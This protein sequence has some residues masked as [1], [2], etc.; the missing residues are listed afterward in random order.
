MSASTNNDHESGSG[1]LP[2]PVPLEFFDRPQSDAGVRRFRERLRGKTANSLMS[3][4]RFGDYQLEELIGSGAMGKVYKARHIE[5]GRI[6]AVKVMASEFLQNSEAVQRFHKEARL[7]SDV[8]SQHITRMYDVSSHEDAI[9]IV[10]EFVNGITVADLLSREVRLS[11]QRALQIAIDLAQALVD[12]GKKGIIHRDIKPE[13]ILLESRSSEDAAS[14]RHESAWTVKLS[15]FGLARH[16]QQSQ[17]LAMTREHAVLGTPMYMAPEQFSDQS[18]T[19]ARSDIYSF[20]ATLYHMLA[21]RGPFRGTD[22]LELAEQHR[23][24]PPPPLQQLRSDAS[25]GM[26]QVVARCL[27]KRPELRYP[28]AADLLEDLKRLQRGE[29]TGILVH[30]VVPDINDSDNLLQYRFE[31]TLRSSPNQLW[32]FVSNTE[33][34][35]QAIG[36]PAVQYSTQRLPDGQLAIFAD[37]RVAG[38]SLKWRE[39]QFEWIEQRRM[40]VLREFIKGPLKWF[41]SVVEFF[42]L[43]DGGTRLVHSFQIAPQGWFGNAFAR[44]NFGVDARRSLARVYQRIDGVL[45]ATQGAEYSVDAFRNPETISLRG[46]QRLNQLISQLQTSETDR[47]TLLAVSDFICVAPAQDIGRIQPLRLASRLNL[48]QEHVLFIL[49]RGVGAGLFQLAWDVI[50]PSCRIATRTVDALELLQAHEHCE[51]CQLDFETDLM[52]R[53]EAIFRVHP[54]IRHADTGTYCIGGPA[55]SPHVAAQTR[56]HPQETLSLGLALPSGHYCLR[57]PQLPY[58]LNFK[59]AEGDRN[60]QA[61]QAGFQL[62][63]GLAEDWQ[64][65]AVLLKSNSQWLILHNPF[66]REVTVRVERMADQ[67]DRLSAARLIGVP[68]FRELM[69]GDAWL[70]QHLTAIGQITL[71]KTAIPELRS[72]AS[73][74]S[75]DAR[76]QCLFQQHLQ[77]LSDLCR[78]CG[79]NW[80][81]ITDVGALMA[82]S[83]AEAASQCARQPSRPFHPTRKQP[84]GR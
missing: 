47:E 2:P 15:D 77:K 45:A 60:S 13:N 28:S 66:D 35:N 40:G 53:I 82:F 4:S 36:L 8:D 81:K 50:C 63:V 18:E 34:L 25:D 84:T 31:W 11:E 59:V 23:H 17:S 14:A 19:D 52:T 24:S 65:P 58:S 12:I 55:H 9:Y 48:N 79:G 1:P 16:T 7:L 49:L 70:P 20:G 62:N 80:V 61:L 38:V 26:S 32:P 6:F 64:Q 41:T 42:P 21:G 71:L 68:A 67:Q 27:Q 5:S 22:L 69:Q 75:G 56:L 73:D 46:Q 54:Q 39:H 44:F 37:I 83:D 57:G 10:M 29:A 3:G 33:R 51:A 43:L 78:Q 74:S 76:R 30:P 72:S